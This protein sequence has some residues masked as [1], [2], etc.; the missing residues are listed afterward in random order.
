V[1]EV[2]DIYVV[3]KADRPG[4]DA[5]L[6]EL[7]LLMSSIEGTLQ[8][9]PPLLKTCAV[10]GEGV[11]EILKA[12]LEHQEFLLKNNLLAQRRERQIINEL[13]FIVENNLRSL[14]FSTQAFSDLFSTLAKKVERG[15]VDTYT[16]ADTIISHLARTLSETYK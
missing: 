9:K 15:E 16:A 7:E 1:M 4:A 12:F 5:L 10:S 13:R 11:E 8:W 14:A 2:A 6:M 3:N